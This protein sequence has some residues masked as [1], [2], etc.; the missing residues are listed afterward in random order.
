MNKMLK[1]LAVAA[2]SLSSTLVL[3]SPTYLVTHNHTDVQSNAY[4]AGVVP[5]PVPTNPCSEGKVHWALVRMSCYSQMIN[6]R[7]PAV[8]KMATNT[9][10][11]IILGM[12]SMDVETGDILPKQISANGYTFTVNGPGE[13]TLTQSFP[14]QCPLH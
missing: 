3:A 4:V 13:G 8:I 5:S 14:G 6:G 7:C 12:V 1:G 10:A 2:L 11:P 9:A